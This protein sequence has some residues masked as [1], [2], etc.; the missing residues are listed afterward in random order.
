[1]I[2]TRE[3]DIPEDYIE[4]GQFFLQKD[5]KYTFVILRGEVIDI[6]LINN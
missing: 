4:S 2:E 3:T 1:M 6:E 5:S